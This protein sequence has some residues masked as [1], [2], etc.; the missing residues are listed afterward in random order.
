MIFKSDKFV[1]FQNETFISKGY[2]S[3]DLFKM[4]VMTNQR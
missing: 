4:N 3:D 2:I 1:L